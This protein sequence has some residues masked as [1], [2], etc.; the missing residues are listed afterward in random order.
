MVSALLFF[1]LSFLLTPPPTIILAPCHEILFIL[2][3]SCSLSQN[4]FDVTFDRVTKGRHDLKS[5]K[6]FLERRAAIEETYA[7]SLIKLAKEGDFEVVSSLGRC[8]SDL[9]D[10]TRNLAQQHQQLSATFTKEICTSIDA[11]VKELKDTKSKLQKSHNHL[12]DDVK[13]RSKS[14]EKAKTKY[15]QAVKTAETSTLNKDAGMK[16]Q[17]PEKTLAEMQ[18]KVAKDMKDVESTHAHYEKTVA[19]LKDAQQTYDT[20]TASHLATFESLENNRMEFLHSQFE[21]LSQCHEFIK[22]AIDQIHVQLAKGVSEVSIPNDIKA[23]VDENE[24]KEDREPHVQYLPCRSNIINHA[25]DVV[26]AP[27]TTFTPAPPAANPKAAAAPPPQ[28]PPAAS[29]GSA[30]A[31]Y[32]KAEYDFEFQ[33]EGDLGFKENDII[34]LI[35]DSD[36]SWWKGE[37]RGKVGT[38]PASYVKKISAGEAEALASAPAKSAEAADEGSKCR[39]LFDFEAQS[40]DELTFAAGEILTI[41]SELDGWYLGKTA[42]GS[43]GIFPANYVEML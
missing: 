23:F 37:L 21:R 8:W 41:T 13:K 12:V 16:E 20:E 14:H 24:A 11:K 22:G 30:A 28:A 9:K 2:H 25:T 31:V 5:L 36:P 33:A 1:S 7:K 40:E 27:A 6:S 39:A 29:G 19:E 26:A 17:L 43:V 32:L 10:A 4:G 3:C 15:Y 34:K 18:K 35:D 38:F 42:A